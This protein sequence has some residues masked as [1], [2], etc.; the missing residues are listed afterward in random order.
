MISADSTGERRDGL[1]VRVRAWAAATTIWRSA[2]PGNSRRTPEL[3]QGSRSVWTRGDFDG[4]GTRMFHGPRMRA[5]GEASSLRASGS[6]NP[7]KRSSRP[8]SASRKRCAPA[9]L[10]DMDGGRSPRRGARLHDR[11]CEV[12]RGRRDGG[13]QLKASSRGSRPCTRPGVAGPRPGRGRRSLCRAP[14]A[15]P[16]RC[17]LVERNDVPALGRPSRATQRYEGGTVRRR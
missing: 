4:A 14:R 12:W 13:L 5:L 16:A 2:V 17:N 10:A 6:S 1:V 11:P 3:A 7:G 9:D 15:A 8:P